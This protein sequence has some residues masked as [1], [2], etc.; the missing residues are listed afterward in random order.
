MVTRRPVIIVSAAFP[1]HVVG[2]AEVNAKLLANYLHA[3]GQDVQVLTGA[4]IL[5]KG[6]PYPI[7]SLP[8]LRPRPS[9]IYEPWWNRRTARR[10]SGAIPHGAIV[11]TFDLLGR[12]VIA[13][14][15]PHRPDLRAVATLQD[16]SPACGSIDGILTDGTLCHGCTWQNLFRHQRL[17]HYRGVGKL[18]RAFRYATACVKP[19]RRELLGRFHALTTVSHFLNGFLKLQEVPVIPDLLLPP[20]LTCKLERTTAPSLVSVGRMSEDKGT[21]LTLRALAELPQFLGTFVGGGDRDYWQQKARQYGVD[22]RVQIVGQVPLR[23][24]GAYYAAADVVVQ[25]SRCPEA[26]SRTLLE[27]MSLGKAVVGPNYAGP[28]ELITEGSTGRLF[29]RGSAASLAAAIDRAYRERQRLGERA[30]QAAERYLP[31]KVGPRY[32][33]LYERILQE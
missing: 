24:V 14:L 12:G 5:P 8:A 26:S 3:Q 20:K 17:Q 2:G 23:S 28:A 4:S 19:Y 32:L 15:L 25:A 27:A 13:E 6:K 30:K 16:I 31:E 21:D 1:P 33:E 29:E 7:R 22:G 18:A 11:H 9:I 10:V